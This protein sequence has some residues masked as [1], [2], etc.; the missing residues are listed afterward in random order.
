[1]LV[2]NIAFFDSGQGGLT[3]WE[4]VSTAFPNLN[5]HYLGDTGR[6]PYG[7]RSPDLICQYT[8]EGLSFLVQ[9]GAQF[10]VVACGT[11]SCLAVA[12]VRDRFPVPVIGIVEG[13]CRSVVPLLRD[14][15]DL[16]AV[17]A[18]RFTVQ[19]QRYEQELQSL[20]FHRVWSRACPLWA[21]IVE[22]GLMEGP[23]VEHACEMYLSD[24]PKDVR[25]VMLGCTHYPRMVLPIAQN[26]TRTCGRSVIF[27]SVQGDWLLTRG[28]HGDPI[29]LTEASSFVVQAIGDFLQQHP[30]AQLHQGQQR[31][32]CTDDP[33]RFG[34]AARVFTSRTLA[35]VEKVH[36]YDRTVG[37]AF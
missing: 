7:T 3:V 33:A 30:N 36:I 19:S 21:P 16:V 26:L 17:L 14:K 27:R 32:F 8:H 6:F 23:L 37:T 5:T 34:V 20:G 24:I 25:V 2:P 31:F 18:T 9:Q 22:E 11:A 15:D 29:Y 10:V 1:M 12:R 28:Q 4:S 35:S 13:F